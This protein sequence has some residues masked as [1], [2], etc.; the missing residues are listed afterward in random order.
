MARNRVHI[1]A[2]PERVWK[3]LADPCCYPDW[4]VGASTIRDYD[5]DFPAVGTR[6]HHKVGVWPVR[7]ADNSEVL[8]VEEGRRL[9][10]K[11]KA[12]P[13]GTARVELVL[14]AAPGG[15]L[16]FMEEIP[17][18]RLTRLVA[19]NPVADRLLL[20][21]NAEALSRLKR[22]AED[23]RQDGAAARTGIELDGARA[24]VTGA[25]SGI[26][27]ATAI[28]LA[29]QGARLAILARSRAG[30]EKAA[31]KI[32]ARG[33]EPLILSADV[34]DETALRHAVDEAVTELGGLDLVVAAAAGSSFGTFEETPADQF[35]R[36]VDVVFGGTVNTLRATMPALEESA[37]TIVILGSLAGKLPLPGL[38]AYTAAKHAIRGLVNTLRVELREA[39]SP[40]SISLV[41]PGPVDTPFRDHL[42]S[43]TG[44]LPPWPKTAYSADTVADAILSCAR[45]PREEL[46]IGAAFRLQEIAFTLFR[47][48]AEGTLT[49]VTR[50]A[51]TGADRLAR[52]DVLAEGS[53]EGE[54]S[55]G[56]SGRPSV[57]V[58]AGRIKEQ[59]QD[60]VSRLG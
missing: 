41:H 58:A 32:S 14:D 23:K 2:S 22:L 43:A 29:D 12:R 5:E 45:R 42:S 39:G 30:L 36:T 17:H 38:T 35:D 60:L 27:L 52:N 3:V 25:S 44:L 24:L 48:A 34:S 49:T 4:V 8:E 40:V 7:L 50:G 59:A 6:F 26:G 21:R 11:V 13:L 16:V 20:V 19:A 33:E 57:T 54:V 28:K 56:H 1:A 10:L 46:T 9:V 37:G 51:R 18:D 47:K 55:G 31:A 15:T 53:G